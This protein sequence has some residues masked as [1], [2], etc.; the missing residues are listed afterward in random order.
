MS[1]SARSIASAAPRQA[2]SLTIE[3]FPPARPDGIDALAETVGRLSPLEPEFVSV[4]YGA[5][6]STRERSRAVVGRLM[7]ETRGRVAAHV[8]C[9]AC[10]AEET[11][12]V[13]DEFIEMGVRRFFALRGDVPGEGV[14]PGSYADAASLVRALAGR[15]VEDISVAAY[16]EVHPK[17]LSPE[18]DIAALKAKMD[19]GA[20]R[21]VTQ[22]FL[23]NAAFYRFRDRLAAEALDAPLVPGVLLFEDYERAANFAD[24]CGTK[25]PEGVKKRFAATANDPSGARAEA[26]NFLAWQI[27]DLRSN[28]VERFHLYALNRSE[29]ALAL[30]RPE[31][32]A[33]MTAAA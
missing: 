29:T 3:V 27:S 23:D 8:T 25:V 11:D 7:A 30:F 17:A 9:V 18:A 24:R 33:A 20:N 21:A 12:H 1:A 26:L 15:G 2:P 19:A 10:T 28:G 32:A 6:G 14:R 5:G 16:P 31:F 4:T 22:F 13:V